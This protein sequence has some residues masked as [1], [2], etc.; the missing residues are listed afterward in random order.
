[1]RAAQGATRPRVRRE[2][3]ACSQ[4]GSK[5]SLGGPASGHAMPRASVAGRQVGCTTRAA[6]R[7]EGQDLCTK[8]VEGLVAYPAVI[9]NQQH[10]RRILVSRHSCR[11]ASCLWRTPTL[12]RARARHAHAPY[13]LRLP[14]CDCVCVCVCT[15]RANSRGRSRNTGRIAKE[16][17]VGRAASDKKEERPRREKVR[18]ER[19][20]RRP[21]PGPR[22]SSMS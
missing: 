2:K 18:R 4:I 5:K 10:G 11:V 17:C 1:M 12:P 20:R 21:R 14:S 6:V 7:A 22:T 8:V 9:R 15:G 19:D 16:R 3:E 13:R